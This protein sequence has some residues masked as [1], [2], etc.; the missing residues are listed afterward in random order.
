MG[1]SRRVV[2][3]GDYDGGNAFLSGV[4]VERAGCRMAN[5]SE[6]YLRFEG[7]SACIPCSST[8]IC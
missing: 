8:D 1:G 2:V 3:V 6:P 5:S 7:R 4:G